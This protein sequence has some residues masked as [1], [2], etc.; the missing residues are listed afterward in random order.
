MSE[1]KD[2]LLEIVKAI[3]ELR[4]RRGA[5]NKQISEFVRK[6]LR[7]SKEPIKVY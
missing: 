7:K 6:R 5:T 2:A 4:E 1:E 3:E